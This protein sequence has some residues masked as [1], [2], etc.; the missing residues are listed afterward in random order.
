VVDLARDMIRLSGLREGTDI[1]IQFT[2]TL[3]GEKLYEEM[4]LDEESARRT[5]HPKVL[6]V[7]QEMIDPW[8]ERLIDQLV[9]SAI[10]GESEDNLRHMLQAIVPE[11]SA[12]APVPMM[13]TPGFGVKNQEMVAGR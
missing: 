8:G 12:N 10:N 5:T 7:R 11:F 4:M 6:R 3:P 9:Q 1:E 13:P 2:G